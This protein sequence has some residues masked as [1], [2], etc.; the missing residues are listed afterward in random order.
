MRK[1]V[2]I[3]VAFVLFNSRA[4]AQDFRCGLTASPLISWYNVAGTDIEN[5]GSRLGFQ[6]GLLFEPTIGS[7]E[8]YAFSTGV[9]VNMVGGFLTGTEAYSP[10]DTTLTGVVN[11]SL[12]VQ[13]LEV[14][15][16]IKLRTNEIN[17][18]SYYGMFG[19]TPG[20]N[21]K[22][23]YDQQL[24]NGDF[25]HEDVNLNGNEEG[26]D[27]EY[28]FMNLSLSMGIGTE[29][30]ITETTTL[31]AGLVFQNGFLNVYESNATDEMI[32]M[33]QMVLRLGVLF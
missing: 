12:R 6:Y 5:D 32:Q 18:F 8:R 21:I 15:L 1:I 16:T 13:Y 17:Y 7:V 9:V 29:Y 14:P 3:I 22:A 26:V 33:K 28:R 2:V 20:F 11:T 24:E 23:R 31:T 27:D 4:S 30:S 10:A 19:I 25:V